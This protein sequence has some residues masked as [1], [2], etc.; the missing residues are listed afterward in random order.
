[1]LCIGYDFY[2]NYFDDLFPSKFCIIKGGVKVGL[3]RYY[4][5]NLEKDFPE[6]YQDLKC[7]FNEQQILFKDTFKKIFNGDFA[8]IED[9]LYEIDSG[10]KRNVEI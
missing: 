4:M 6:M 10:K 7:D 1:M 3:P 8:R 5:N 9:Y 2:Q